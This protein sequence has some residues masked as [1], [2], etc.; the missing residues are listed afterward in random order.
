MLS[1]FS[2][3]SGCTLKAKSVEAC[4]DEIPTFGFT[5]DLGCKGGTSLETSFSLGSFCLT[6]S[7]GRSTELR[8][9]T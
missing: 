9:A 2:L 5:G 4:F 8:L 3:D 7:I 1:P 6:S